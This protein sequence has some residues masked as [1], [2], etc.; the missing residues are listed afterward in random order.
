MVPVWLCLV[1]YASTVNSQTGSSNYS[2]RLLPG[3]AN[4]ND[5]LLEDGYGLSS[6]GLNTKNIS[7]PGNFSI[8]SITFLLKNTGYIELVVNL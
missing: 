6:F 3:S 7:I 4:L 8:R 2:F 1:I 5:L